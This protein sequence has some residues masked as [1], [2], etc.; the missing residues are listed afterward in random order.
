MKN[1]F[2]CDRCGTVIEA[3]TKKLLLFQVHIHERNCSADD[4]SK[5]LTA[6]REND[7]VQETD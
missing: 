6:L 2:T 1:S 4:L 5:Q 3:R 7:I